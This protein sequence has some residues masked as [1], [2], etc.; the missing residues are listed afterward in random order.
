MSALALAVAGLAAC[1]ERSFEAEEFV[2]EANSHGAGLELGEPLT[3]T[4]PESEVYALRLAEPAVEQGEEFGVVDEHAHGGGSLTVTEDEDG[5]LEEYRR[6]ESAASL[7]CYRAANVVVV[8]E[9]S[10]PPE[11]RSRLDAAL[12]SL[13]S[14]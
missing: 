1:G 8:F 13:A 14:E 10:L 7:L 2:D 9:E 11:D 3:T 12:R 4:E 5:A 6:C